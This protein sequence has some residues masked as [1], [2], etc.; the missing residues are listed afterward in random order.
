M[1]E[2]VR[3]VREVMEQTSVA[4]LLADRPAVVLE[5][6]ARG[7]GATRW[8]RVATVHDLDRL[9]GVLSPGSRVS[10]YFDD[11]ICALTWGDEAVVRVLD[12]VTEHGDA[13][14]GIAQKGEIELVVQ[15]VAGANELNEVTEGLGK[16]TRVFVGAFP[17]ADDTGEDSVT[18]VLPDR[19]GVLRAH[20]H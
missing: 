3:H 11:R 19:D 15:V 9:A 5:R 17:A 12:L 16:G 6:I 14:V 18:V 10:F 7:A 2:Y 4:R 8:F 13:V 1:S 20:P